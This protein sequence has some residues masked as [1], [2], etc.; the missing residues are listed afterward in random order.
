[1]TVKRRSNSWKPDLLATSTPSPNHPTGTSKTV[2]SPPSL[3]PAEEGSPTQPSGSR[4]SMMVGWQGTPPR[5]ALT[6][7]CTCA[8]SMHPP[9]IQLTLWSLYPIGSTKPFKG[10]P[11]DMLPSLMQSRLWTIGGLRL[12]LS[13]LGPSTSASSPTKPSSTALTANSR[14]QSSPETNA[15][16]SWSARDFPSGFCIWQENCRACLQVDGPAGDGRRDEDVTSKRQCDVIDLTNKD[17]SSNEE[18]L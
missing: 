4:S 9:S 1:M 3:S 17:S 16:D 11:P 18:E 2:G 8:R 7:S 5:T 14:V 13:D 6:T 15:E 10:Q 12:T